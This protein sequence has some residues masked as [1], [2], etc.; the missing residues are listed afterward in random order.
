[1][2]V[3]QSAERQEGLREPS[4]VPLPLAAEDH[5][6][7]NQLLL[8]Q[9]LSMLD[10]AGRCLD[11]VTVDHLDDGIDA[12]VKA[13]AASIQ[14]ASDLLMAAGTEPMVPIIKAMKPKVRP[15]IRADIDPDDMRLLH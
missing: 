10:T 12:R 13:A 5:R 15:S 9:A 1:M 8:D 11:T 14:N 6:K 3:P 7:N 2:T 4:I